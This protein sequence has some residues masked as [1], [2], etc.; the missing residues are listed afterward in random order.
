VDRAGRLWI[1]EDRN[2]TVMMVRRE[3]K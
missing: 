3:S 2:K 1:V